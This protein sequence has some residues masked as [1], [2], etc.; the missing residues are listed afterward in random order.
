MLAARLSPPVYRFHV[1]VDAGLGKIKKE[2]RSK[3]TL[4]N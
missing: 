4:L 1:V 2:G 3:P